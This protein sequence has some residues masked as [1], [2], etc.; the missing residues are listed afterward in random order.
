MKVLVLHNRYQQRGGE[1]LAVES[2]DRLLTSMGHAVVRYHRSNTDIEQFTLF[3]KA[4]LPASTLWSRKSFREA[5]STVR[6]EKPNVAHFHNTLPLISPSA[7][8]ACKDAGIPLVQTLHNYRLLCPA[9]TFFR[10]AQPCE[11]CLG[12]TVPWPGIL[13]ACYRDSRVSTGVVAAMLTMHRALGT[14]ADLLDV[15]IALS[16]FAKNK[17]IEGGLPAGKI[18]VKPNFVHPDPGAD[19]DPSDYALFVGRLSPEKG[20]GTLLA[21]WKQMGNSIPL[22]VLGDGPLRTELEAQVKTLGLSSVRFEG[23]VDRTAVF[24]AMKR[25]RFL[26]VPSQC[27]ENFPTTIVEAFACGLPT[28]AAGLGAIREIVADGHTGLHFDPGSSLD[29][30]GKVDWAVVHPREMEAMGQAGRADYVGK[31]TAERNYLMLM[32]I[33]ERAIELR[34]GRGSSRRTDP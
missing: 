33:Y 24:A 2:E 29:L 28:I 11:L 22:L 15:Y 32:D 6:Q 20:V 10:A 26:V 5:R 8:S 19:R 23:R 16:E 34:L 13:H 7:Y 27:Y 4:L 9:A 17:F 12:K 30:A 1:D 18:V 14:W 25:A 21:A 31:Y 3:E